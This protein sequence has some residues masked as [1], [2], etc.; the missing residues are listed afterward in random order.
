MSLESSE[1]GFQGPRFDPRR[2]RHK[3]E[4]VSPLW[5]S[6]MVTSTRE[7]V[8]LKVINNHTMNLFE[9]DFLYGAYCGMKISFGRL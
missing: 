6:P 1:A 4:G 2:A 7:D 3:S 5:A 9:N 8:L